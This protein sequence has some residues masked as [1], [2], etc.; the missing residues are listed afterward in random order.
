MYLPGVKDLDTSITRYFFFSD[1]D[2]AVKCRFIVCSFF[3]AGLIVGVFM[4]VRHVRCSR[5]VIY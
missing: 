1:L 3:F 5:A 4:A 2:A